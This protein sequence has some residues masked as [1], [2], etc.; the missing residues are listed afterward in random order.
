[1]GRGIFITGTDT[2]VGKTVITAGLAAV[3]K[4][5]GLQV[6]VMK[7]IQTGAKLTNG[8]LESEDLKLL[9]KAAAIDE[10]QELT[11]PYCLAL[12][13][14]PMLAAQEA[15]IQIDLA[16]IQ[17]AYQRLA[18]RYEVVLVEGA[19]GLLVPIHANYTFLDLVRDLGLP[20]LIVARATLGT[21]NHTALTV[22]CAQNAGVPIWGIILNHSNPGSEGLVEKNN[23]TI[24]EQLTGIPVWGIIPYSPK[25]SVEQ[26]EVGDIASL[27]EKHLRLGWIRERFN[28]K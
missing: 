9:V 25:I 15:G 4:A 17:Q 8:G 7:P 21:I 6:G 26:T 24:I 12:A 28:F 22:A 3:L 5:E 20:L 19:G 18:E 13:A 16:R 1:M 2:G 11:N 14:A 27:M 23:P 10:P